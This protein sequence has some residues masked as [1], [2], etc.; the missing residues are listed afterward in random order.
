MSVDEEVTSPVIPPA[1][2]QDPVFMLHKARETV[3]KVFLL[4]CFF[5]AILDST[6]F[7]Y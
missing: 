5:L 3:K 2:I 1:V 7:I 4:C 6:N